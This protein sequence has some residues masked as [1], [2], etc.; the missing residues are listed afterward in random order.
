MLPQSYLQQITLS[1]KINR[2]FA[3][4]CREIKQLK[5]NLQLKYQTLAQLKQSFPEDTQLRSQINHQARKLNSLNLNLPNFLIIGTQK[6]GTTWLHENL[7]RHPQ[8]IFY[9]QG[10]KGTRI[11]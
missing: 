6:G 1:S 11:L 10:K 2:K 9:P 5:G 8:N 3:Q 7:K 4:L